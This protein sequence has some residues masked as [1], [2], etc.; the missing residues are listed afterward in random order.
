MTRS[1]DIAVVGGGLTGACAAALLA[2]HGGL[3]PRRMLLIAG[4]LPAVMAAGA[5][6][7]LRVVAISRA[8][9]RVLRAAVAWSAAL[10]RRLC[11]YERMVVWQESGS[12]DAA[13]A[14]RFDAADIGE[15]NLGYIAETRP[16]QQACL[17]SFASAGG[18][19]IASE[20]L[21]LSLRPDAAQLVCSDGQEFTVKL[22]IGA[23]GAQ[24]A[25]RRCAGLTVQQHDYLQDAI[26][27]TV[28][29]ERPH[30]HT[31]WQRFLRT[32][33][34]AL[35][36]LFDGSCS[37]VWS[38]D[39]ALVAELRDGAEASFNERLEQAVDGALGR[40]TLASERRAFP[41][42]SMT[43]DSYIAPRCALVGDAAHVIH[44][45]AGQGA[46]LGLLDAAALCET[47][48]DGVAQREDPGALRL[49]RHYEQQRR[50]HNL[51]MDRAMSAL[52]AGF[53]RAPGPL[54]ALLGRGLGLVDRSAAL[55]RA[56]A[57]RALGTVG[58][59]PRLARAPLA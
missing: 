51:L 5:P 49:L 22:L 21:R 45:L 23:D 20:L 59:L 2:R 29:S 52:R 12:A 46:N 47:L 8:S 36:P 57:R 27:A 44:P 43:A 41:L 39:R 37:L 53:S 34:V 30:Q 14:L 9:E 16:L 38:I 6:P 48:A 11:P 33:P 17:E 55:K 56:F 32:G 31:A 58:E 7:D 1:Y 4:E 50:T 15:P 19:L 18:T 54:A 24:S 13:Q 10:E 35:L 26:V 40:M 42:Q 28:R 25:V 3:D